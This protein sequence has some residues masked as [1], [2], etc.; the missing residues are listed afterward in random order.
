MYE[1]QLT[2]LNFDI[3]KKNEIEKAANEEWPFEEF[4]VSHDDDH[5]GLW[6]R[7]ESSL[8]AVMELKTFITR[9]SEAIWKAN[10]AFCTVSVNALCQEGTEDDTF[11][12]D[13]SAY[14]AMIQKKFAFDAR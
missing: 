5:T 4:E 8:S 13:N 10:G 9:L 1:M 11:E 7:G 6:S 14:N 3:S 12:P 2:V